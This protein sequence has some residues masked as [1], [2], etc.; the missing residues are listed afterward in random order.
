MP[1]NEIDE[2]DLIDFMEGIDENNLPELTRETQEILKRRVQDIKDPIRYVVI[3]CFVF[4]KEKDVLKAIKKQKPSAI[5]SYNVED[6]TF[7]FNSWGTLFKKEEIAIS[8]ANALVDNKDN[9]K[10]NSHIHYFVVKIE[11]YAECN[12]EEILEIKEII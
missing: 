11:K 12:V 6:H 1:N 7:S 2:Y 3:N 4:K 8:V 10:K 5:F 9:K